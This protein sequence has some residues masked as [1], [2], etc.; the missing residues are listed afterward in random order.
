MTVTVPVR[1][2]KDTSAF[3]DLVERE[4]NVTVTKNGYDVFHCL[5]S[6]E[7]AI[8]RDEIAKAKLLSRILLAEREIETGDYD[9]YDAF[10]AEVRAEYGL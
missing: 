6:N 4:R 7:W 3:A 2:M 10:V 9:D 1:D 5:S 8:Q